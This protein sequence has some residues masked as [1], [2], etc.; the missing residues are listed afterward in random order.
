MEEKIEQNNI[1]IKNEKGN[2]EPI[3]KGES[4]GK[5]LGE[6]LE[7]SEAEPETHE[8]DL[9]RV[10]SEYPDTVISSENKEE[11]KRTAKRVEEFMGKLTVTKA[12]T[13][14]SAKM[15]QKGKMKK[16]LQSTINPDRR[17]ESK[18]SKENRSN[19]K[20]MNADKIQEI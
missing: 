20:E 18:K 1:E 15:N 7:P 17:Q 11:L 2:E 4:L 5:V 3:E 13:I 14:K 19:N 6:Y 8:E 9:K 10:L 12:P 16:E